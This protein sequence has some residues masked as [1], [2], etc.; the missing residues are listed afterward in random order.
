VL[1][2]LESFF[3]WA[4]ARGEIEQGEAKGLSEKLLAMVVVDSV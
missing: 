4:R 1:L 2:L 3:S